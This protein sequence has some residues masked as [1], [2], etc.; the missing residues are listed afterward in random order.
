M[1]PA[2]RTPPRRR[3]DVALKF[4]VTVPS[5]AQSTG[6]AKQLGGEV[7]AER[8]QGPGFKLC[9]AMDC[10]GNVFQLRERL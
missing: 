7:F 5:I 9:N 10:E 3:E 2:Y 6:A 4:F 8:W 1:R